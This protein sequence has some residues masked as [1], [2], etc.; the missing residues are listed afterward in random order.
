MLSSRIPDNQNTTWNTIQPKQLTKN[1]YCIAQL[2]E[3]T[4]AIKGLTGK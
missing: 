2:T 3:E 1:Y 4:G